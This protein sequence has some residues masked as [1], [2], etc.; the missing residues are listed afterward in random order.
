MYYESTYVK[1]IKIAVIIYYPILY[2]RK[3]MYGLRLIVKIN[4]CS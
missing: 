1:K 2:L 4:L 3:T